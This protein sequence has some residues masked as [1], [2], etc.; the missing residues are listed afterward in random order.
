MINETRSEMIEIRINDVLKEIVNVFPEVADLE[1]HDNLPLPFA[2]YKVK[3]F[4][5]KTKEV[6]RS[7]V[8]SVNVLSV[9]GEYDESLKL[10]NKISEAM[11]SLQDSRTNVSFLDSS[12]EFDDDDRAWVTEMNFEIKV[13]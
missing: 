5:S 2:V 9:C 3:R 12:R 8:Y 4:G 10:E 7:G 11:L 13:Y 6:N 1:G